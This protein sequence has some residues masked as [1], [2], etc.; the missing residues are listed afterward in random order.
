MVG[1]MSAAASAPPCHLIKTGCA[2]QRYV[3]MPRHVGTAQ[4]P[5]FYDTA[6]TQGTRSPCVL[7]AKGHIRPIQRSA[8]YS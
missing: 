8:L 7:I 3:Q 5:I 4:V 2:V 1:Q 6:S